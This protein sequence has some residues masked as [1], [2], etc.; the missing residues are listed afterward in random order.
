M[1]GHQ[2]IYDS[3]FSSIN[4]PYESH[5]FER[6]P[7]HLSCI[8][9]IERSVNVGIMCDVSAPA[10]THRIIISREFLLN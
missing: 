3:Y 2:T 7:R 4:M 1:R 8:N 9:Q 6:Q 5:T 10:G